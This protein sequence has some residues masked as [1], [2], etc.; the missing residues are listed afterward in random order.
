MRPNMHSKGMWTT[1][2]KPSNEDQG[3][4]MVSMQLPAGAI[5]VCTDATLVTV[6]QIAMSM[7]EVDS[8]IGVSGFSFTG[9]GQNMAM[10][11][12]MLNL[13]E[14]VAGLAVGDVHPYQ[15]HKIS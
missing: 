15:S 11:F 13:L 1:C 3:T 7:P 2:E 9:S 4:L 6:T 12:V 10:G 14:P 8:M 5:K